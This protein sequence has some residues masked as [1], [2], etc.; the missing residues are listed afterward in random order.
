MGP[1][2]NGLTRDIVPAD[3]HWLPRWI[4]E[5]DDDGVV[6]TNS[7]LPCRGEVSMILG[8]DGSRETQRA[9][10]QAYVGVGMENLLEEMTWEVEGA[11]DGS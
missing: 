4:V 7:S 11:V 8:V 2:L 6:L 1:S 3:G 9:V 10:T 5:Y